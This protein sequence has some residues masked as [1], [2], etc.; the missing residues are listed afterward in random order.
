M[1]RLYDFELSGSCYKI[2]LFMNIL[3][4]EYESQV[5]D[6]VNKEHKNTDYLKLNAFGEIP[7]LEDGE[8][9]LRDAQAI[10]VYL[11]KKYDRSGQWFPEDA[12][13]AGRVA[14]WLA[15]GGG[16][17]MNSAGARLV[18][19]LNYPLDLEKLQ[20]GAKHVFG[21]LNDHLSDREWLELER[22][23]IA[24]IACFPYTALAGEGGI[25]LSPYPHVRRWIKR[26]KAMPRFIP[27]PGV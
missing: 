1:I 12:A 26:V 3:G 20:L 13:S 25:D 18:K 7:I 5:V 24:D 23:T 10:L 22:P 16:E 2:R 17:I 9:R 27:M 15:T 14:Q 19:I 4:L 21:I 8:L 6:F 11:A